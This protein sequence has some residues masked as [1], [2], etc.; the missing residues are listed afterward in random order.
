M[1]ELVR[2]CRFSIVGVGG[3]VLQMASLALFRHL[4]GA[5]YLL[6]SAAALE[7]TLLHNFVWHRRYTWRDRR[8]DAP[9]TQLAR[10]HLSNGAVSFAG[11]LSIVH[12]LVNNLRLGLLAANTAAVICCALANFVLGNLWA[13]ARPKTSGP[14]LLEPDGRVDFG[15]PTRT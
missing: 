15:G 8:A 3:F 4:C 14:I 11:S 7:L 9:L 13:F 10:F 5:H 12:L 1:N 2:W 6:A